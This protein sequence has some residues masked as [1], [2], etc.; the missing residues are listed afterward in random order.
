MRSKRLMII[1]NKT[2]NTRTRQKEST[3]QKGE[4]ERGKKGIG[5]KKNWRDPTLADRQLQW[6]KKS[7]LL[8]KVKT[9]LK[10]VNL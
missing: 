2:L 6:E 5:N 7:K 1:K 10:V 8:V 9:Y 4:W 3:Q